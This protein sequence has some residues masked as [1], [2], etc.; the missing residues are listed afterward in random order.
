MIEIDI[1]SPSLRKLPIF[2]AVGIPEVWRYRGG[3]VT[4]FLLESGRYS[5]APRSRA[6]PVVT[7]EAL[8]RFLTESQQTR[9][10]EWLRRVRAWIRDALPPR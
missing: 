2:A 6:F 1:T 9:S 3:E 4:I 8:A 5:E 7:S 10:T